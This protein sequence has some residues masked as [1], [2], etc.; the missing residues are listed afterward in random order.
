MNS[1]CIEK[2]LKEKRII[3]SPSPETAIISIFDLRLLPPE[4]EYDRHEKYYAAIS[5]TSF[6]VCT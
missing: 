6:M 5:S 3:I 2:S 4:Y 1:A